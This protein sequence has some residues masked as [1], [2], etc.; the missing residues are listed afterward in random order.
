MFY[1][2]FLIFTVSYPFSVFSVF[3][4]FNFL[5]KNSLKLVVLDINTLFL[6]YTSTDF[7]K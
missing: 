3:S 5:N 4:V 7:S 1:I 2:L 6:P